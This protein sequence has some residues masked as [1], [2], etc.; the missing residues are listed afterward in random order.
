VTLV[1]DKGSGRLADTIGERVKQAREAKGISAS[2]LSR[3]INQSR[4]Y[5]AALERGDIEV[6]SPQ[7]AERIGVELG[8]SP[9]WL[10]GVSDSP[11]LQALPFE[12]LMRFAAERAV[13]EMGKL[14][15]TRIPLLSGSVRAGLWEDEPPA[16]E[17]L[18]YLDGPAEWA[19]RRVWA[20]ISRGDCLDP[21]VRD[22]DVVIFEVGRPPRDGRLVVLAKAG[23]LTVK[24]A[25][26]IDGDLIA[27]RSAEGD[28]PLTA[29]ML[30]VG[31]V[32]ETRRPQDT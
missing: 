17:V 8:V 14:R 32:L 19:G 27:L 9:A 28:L 2:E 25:R 11:N 1:T 21:E 24:V 31:A 12:D 7:I 13:V 30:Y 18:R 6:L 4:T 22:G 23:Q 16:K 15:Q 26:V 5:T 10:L 20:V 3:R 29:D